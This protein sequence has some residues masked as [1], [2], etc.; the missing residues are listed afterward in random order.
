MAHM[1]SSMLSACMLTATVCRTSAGATRRAIAS[2]RNEV[3][4]V[5]AMAIAACTLVRSEAPNVGA[6]QRIEATTV[7]YEKSWRSTRWK[8]SVANTAATAVRALDSKC[9]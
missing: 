8:S 2:A 3:G 9:A 5:A 6:L 1:M 4:H 7:T